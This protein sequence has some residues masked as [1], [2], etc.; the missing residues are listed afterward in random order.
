MKKKRDLIHRK[1]VRSV[2]NI[3]ISCGFSKRNGNLPEFIG[4]KEART[5]TEESRNRERG[6]EI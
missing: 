6:I 1:V 4:A 3:D 5:S 2:F